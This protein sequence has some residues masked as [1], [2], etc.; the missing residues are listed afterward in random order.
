MEL[1]GRR[2]RQRGTAGE[3]VLQRRER[4]IASGGVVVD[5][6]LVSTCR[7][8][9]VKLYLTTIAAG[10]EGGKERRKEG[11]TIHHGVCACARLPLQRAS[12]REDQRPLSALK[13]DRIR[14]D[15]SRVGW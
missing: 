4:R 7:L 12:E 13:R 11:R 5:K 14:R 2:R 9:V 8:F 6:V 10:W 1:S 3:R 15:G